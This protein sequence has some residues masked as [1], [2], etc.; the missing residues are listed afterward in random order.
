MFSQLSPE[1]RR[2]YLQQFGI[3]YSKD[4][5]DGL[6]Q[7]LIVSVNDADDLARQTKEM[8]IAVDTS[9]Q[10]PL[11]HAI[12]DQIH[13]LDELIKDKQSGMCQKLV[14]ICKYQASNK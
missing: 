6:Q 13:Q 3:E 4:F 2:Q 7:Q 5:K 10:T 1:E 14:E 12:V 8:S 9:V 11:F